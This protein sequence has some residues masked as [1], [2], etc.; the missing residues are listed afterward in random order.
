MADKRHQ[1]L[2]GCRKGVGMGTKEGQLKWIVFEMSVCCA[3]I[4]ISTNQRP[5]YQTL[6]IDLSQ[7][8][9]TLLRDILLRDPSKHVTATL[10]HESL[11]HHCSQCRRLR[12]LSTE[13]WLKK[14]WLKHIVNLFI[15]HQYKHGNIICKKV[16]ADFIWIYKVIN[17]YMMWK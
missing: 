13:E 1:G 8:L 15:S 2:E 3:L 6:K 9:A 11:L 14:T 17:V 5:T 12:H 7:A 4:K 10:P 16:D